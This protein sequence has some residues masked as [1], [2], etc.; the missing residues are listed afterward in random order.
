MEQQ[1]ESLSNII[2]ASTKANHQ[3]LEKEVVLRLK[4][5]TGPADYAALLQYFYTYFSQ[6]EAHL[7]PF[8]T[9]NVLPDMQERRKS[10]LILQDIR[11]LGGD[12]QQVAPVSLPEV[13]DALSAMSALYVLEGSTLGG[14]VIVGMLEKRGIST[15]ISFFSGYGAATMSR[16]QTF[17]AALNQLPQST[18]DM[19]RAVNTVRE[20][21]DC[22]LKVFQEV[23]SLQ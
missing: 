7:A 11:D 3:E 19:D 2:K 12:V 22:F 6:I 5:M 23:G 21:F 1:Q 4:A 15:G 16:W 14:S 10:A 13:T 17:V 8:I 20:T 9:A 18:E